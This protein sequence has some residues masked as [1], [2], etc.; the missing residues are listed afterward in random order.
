MN[1]DLDIALRP[2]PAP[3]YTVVTGRPATWLIT[4][5]DPP[6]CLAVCVDINI[7]E[8]IHQLLTDHGLVDVGE[9]L[10]HHQ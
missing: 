6:H 1:G 3:M 7:A 10:D 5:G 2:I 9:V 4:V 8:R